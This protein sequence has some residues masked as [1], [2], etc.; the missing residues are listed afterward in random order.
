M[1][2]TIVVTGVYVGLLIEQG[3]GQQATVCNLDLPGNRRTRR[4]R[5]LPDSGRTTRR[6]VSA[7][8][9]RR[10]CFEGAW[11][12]SRS[13][14]AVCRSLTRQRSFILI[15][16]SRRHGRTGPTSSSTP[17]W[18]ACRATQQDCKMASISASTL[19][20]PP[21]VFIIVPLR[22]HWPVLIMNYGHLR[23]MRVYYRYQAS[24]RLRVLA[25]LVRYRGA[26]LGG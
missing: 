12:F 20:V 11:R 24:S 15:A 22:L 10:H 3:Q 13:A 8:R 21:C 7:R 14:A 4:S 9:R 5:A 17:S 19:T 26:M 1:I 2:A 23:F 25:A 6:S 18:A 16:A